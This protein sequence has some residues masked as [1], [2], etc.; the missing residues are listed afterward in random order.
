MVG[1]R[2][3]AYIW[4]QRG[5]IFGCGA[6]CCVCCLIGCVGSEICGGELSSVRSMNTLSQVL[7]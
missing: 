2:S 5:V 1:S 7:S 3:G 6:R 4:T